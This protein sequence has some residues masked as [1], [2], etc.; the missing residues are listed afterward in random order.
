MIFIGIDI[1]KDHHDIAIINDCGEILNDSLHIENSSVGFKKLHREI[2]SHMKSVKDIHIGMEETGIYHENLRD[3]LIEKGFNV[4][5]INPKLT[6]HSR[7]SSSPRRTKTDKLDAIA[8]TRYI[9]NRY[10]ALHSYTPSLYHLAE[11][12]QLSRS[13]HNKKILF[14]KAK[15]ELKRL[16]QITFPEFLKQ[17]NPYSDWS[18]DILKDY[19]TP[20]HYK[21]LH[22]A[23]LV[24]RIKTKRDRLN[25]AI[26]LKQIAL[27]SIGRGNDLQVFLM[28]AAIDDLKHYQAQLK[29]LKVLISEKMRLFPKILS[30]PGI[31]PINGAT[32]LGETGDIHRFTNKHEYYAFYGCD[33]VIHES[34]NFKLKR[35]KLSKTGNKFLR[36]AIYSASRVACVGPGTDNKFRRKYLSM[37]SK[38]NKH[39]NTIIFAVAKNMVHSLYSMIKHNQYYSDQA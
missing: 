20:S 36:T 11:L 4:Y 13:Y 23:K 9:M 38:D 37:A 17:F 29:D 10:T 39:H 30:M 34:G 7:L 31:G 26:L 19:P 15:T 2:S 18:L 6:Y 5:T 28:Q 32:I 8:I 21:G 14:S 27:E 22:T 16:L 3:F 35:S 12:K 24:K 33:P 25:D 1:A